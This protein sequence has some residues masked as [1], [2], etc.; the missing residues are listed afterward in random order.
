MCEI[1]DAPGDEIGFA[2][3]ETGELDSPTVVIQP[4]RL[5]IGFRARR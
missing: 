5:G 1:I 3:T 2:Q 4:K